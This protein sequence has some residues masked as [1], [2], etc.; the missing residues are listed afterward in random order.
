MLELWIIV[1]ICV[2]VVIWANWSEKKQYVKK[3]KKENTQDIIAG[4]R[5]W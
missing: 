2:S 3:G 5:K 1:L 4:W